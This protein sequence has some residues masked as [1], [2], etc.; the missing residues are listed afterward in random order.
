M[1]QDIVVSGKTVRSTLNIE[2]ENTWEENVPVSVIVE[3]CVVLPIVFS[4]ENNQVV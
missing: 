4:S 3:T 1:A 2:N